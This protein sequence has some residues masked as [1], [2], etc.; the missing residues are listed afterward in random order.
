VEK[1]KYM[2]RNPVCRGLVE[3]PE[4]WPWSSFRHYATGQEGTVEIESGWT[5]H[6]VSKMQNRQAD[7]RESHPSRKER[8]KCGTHLWD[9][10]SLFKDFVACLP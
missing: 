9:V 6:K 8:V 10:I 5:S 7:I 3:K 2:H 4:D 1:L